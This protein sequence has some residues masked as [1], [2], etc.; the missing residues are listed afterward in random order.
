MYLLSSWDEMD[1]CVKLLADD[2][3]S[4]ED[5]K[6]GFLS[7][8]VNIFD[9]L[10]LENDQ[11]PWPWCKLVLYN[12]NMKNEDNWENSKNRNMRFLMNDQNIM[13][14]PLPPLWEKS[15]IENCQ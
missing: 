11:F 7:V 12:K 5:D 10:Y 13:F 8:G 4:A 15:K 3:W 14:I 1:V 9:Q 2:E 6:A